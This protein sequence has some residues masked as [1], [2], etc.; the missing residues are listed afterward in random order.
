MLVSGV[1]KLSVQ[2]PENPAI[3]CRT[4]SMKD[5]IEY[6]STL[7]LLTPSKSKC[8]DTPVLVFG[9]VISQKYCLDLF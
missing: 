3:E 8:Y 9:I 5:I 2:L 4:T 7:D 1:L 6:R